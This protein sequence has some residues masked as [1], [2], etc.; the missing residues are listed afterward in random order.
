VLALPSGE[1][2]E[3]ADILGSLDGTTPADKLWAHE[4][5][6]RPTVGAAAGSA[7]FHWMSVL[8]KYSRA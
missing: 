4:A 3:P 2:L 8:R 6:D 7:P 1:R 5:E